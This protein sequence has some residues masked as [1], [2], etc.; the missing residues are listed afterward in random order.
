MKNKARAGFTLVELI[1]VIAI[2][3][4]L[5]AAAIAGYASIT[6]T[7]RES[8]ARNDASTICN[9]V[10]NRNSLLDNTT[11]DA[12][13]STSELIIDAS[14]ICDLSVVTGGASGNQG[15][16]PVNMQIIVSMPAP[17][18]EA[19]LD[20]IDVADNGEWFYFHGRDA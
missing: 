4:V 18:W 12:I 15:T 2:L 16:G 17:Q 19:A 7:A 3:A 13:R 6:R 9:A 1:V 11:A 14:G 5:A 10:N 8:A 20:L